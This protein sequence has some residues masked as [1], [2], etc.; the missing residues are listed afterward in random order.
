[1]NELVAN[2]LSL[3]LSSN[4]LSKVFTFDSPGTQNDQGYMEG[5]VLTITCVIYS[6][7]S[8]HKL[9]PFI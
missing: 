3:F 1:M 2:V 7:L 4:R 5:N 9:Q 8:S 6:P